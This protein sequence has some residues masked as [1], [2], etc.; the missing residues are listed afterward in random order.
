MHRLLSQSKRFPVLLYRWAIEASL[1]SRGIFLYSTSVLLGHC[2]WMIP[3]SVG[4]RNGQPIFQYFGFIS[5]EGFSVWSLKSFLCACKFWIVQLQYL[6]QRRT[7][8]RCY[9]LRTSA[10]YKLFCSTISHIW[11]G[12]RLDWTALWMLW[13]AYLFNW[14]W[15]FVVYLDKV[16]AVFSLWR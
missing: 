14:W 10:V 6:M 2:W 3:G 11:F 1:Y 13:F 8:L 15:R 9:F 12:P 5:E 7:V 4:S 16:Q